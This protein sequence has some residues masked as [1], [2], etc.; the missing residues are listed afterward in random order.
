MVKQKKGGKNV[1]TI[2]FILII[3]MITILFILKKQQLP[4]KKEIIKI[5]FIGDFS[6]DKEAS[7]N[8]LAVVKIAFEDLNRNSTKKYELVTYN[9]DGNN[10]NSV[11]NAFQL[12][13]KDNVIALVNTVIIN[14][15]D[16]RQDMPPTISV[17]G[18]K[19]ENLKRDTFFWDIHFASFTSDY[20]NQHI[21]NLK[22]KYKNIKS[23]AF[24]IEL[25][26]KFDDTRL[27][28]GKLGRTPDSFVDKIE[29]L[30]GI[31]TTTYLFDK[32]K[33]AN[34][35][36]NIKQ[37]TPDIII[38]L[39]NDENGISFLKNAKENGLNDKLFLAFLP[40]T[41]T[42]LVEEK[43]LP[44]RLIIS[45]PPTNIVGSNDPPSDAFGEFVNKF[46]SLTGNSVTNL[47]LNAYEA[48]SL[49]AYAVSKANIT[50]KPETIKEDRD[51]VIK[52]LWAIR[53]FKSLRGLINP[54]GKTGNF[55]RKYVNTFYIN[56]GRFKS[57]INQTI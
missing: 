31:Q 15:R 5:G 4:E 20:V 12:A 40:T 33:L 49:I 32:E 30:N 13:N 42:M 57:A 23:A 48:A 1:N 56:N 54:D 18:I 38:V 51:K 46:T 47:E 52:E 43:N 26:K 10:K 14:S 25:E 39:V 44:K 50:N 45:P 7:Q 53:N 35:T 27:K 3:I 17:G 36:K 37:K 24:V 9:I 19:N 22:F 41:K 16:L 6:N 29:S 21:S 2:I 28:V 34:I 8:T 55:K 11:A